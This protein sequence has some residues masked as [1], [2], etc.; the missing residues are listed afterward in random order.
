[1]P[2]PFANSHP[3]LFTEIEQFGGTERM[4]TLCGWV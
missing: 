3:I 4:T 2:E 1:M